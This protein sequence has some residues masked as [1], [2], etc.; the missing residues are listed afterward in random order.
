MP[1]TGMMYYAMAAAGGNAYIFGGVA[2]SATINKTY[3]YD[4]ATNAVT[5][6]ADMP[7]ALRSQVALAAGD[8]IYLI[9]GHT[10]PGTP[11]NGTT[12][13][14][15]Y[16]ISGDDWTTGPAMPFAMTWGA[17]AAY[18]DPAHGRVFYVFGGYNA[19]G[20]IVNQSWAY[21]VATGTWEATDNLQTA[22]RSH[23]G[24]IYRDTLLAVCGWGA[25][26]LNTVERG[27]IEPSV[28]ERSFLR[29][30][31]DYGPPDTTLGVRLQ[32]LGDTLTY[33]DVQSYTPTLTELMPYNA[34]GLHSNYAYND[35][36][37]LGN[38]LADY[39]D[40][41][42]GVVPCHFSYS[43]GWNLGGRLMTGDYAT[44]GVGT[45]TH[46]AT[47]LGW[48]NSGHPVMSGVSA[49]GEYFAATTSFTSPDSV[50]RW[51]DGRPYVA[52]SA[53]QK[54]V[55]V[56]SYPGIFPRPERTGDWA[57]VIRNA[58]HYVSG[59]V[60][61]EEFDPVRPA[62]SVRLETAPNPVR[63]QV[64]VNWALPHAGEV[65]VGI[66][67]AGGRLV[68]T[69]F[70]GRAEPGAGRASWNLADSRGERVASGV[71]FCC[72]DAGG[73]SVSSKLVVD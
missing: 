15:K 59:L 24:T 47:T 11:Y 50:A 26:F 9:G 72:L 58:L 63:R 30:Y 61:T 49:V 22:R 4:P 57:L 48:Y 1:Q 73:R 66:Y 65:S 2:A 38:V 51:T 68:R 7:M 46:Q 44:I 19:S 56:N 35:S 3:R 34:V 43:T 39:V 70:T 12:H 6:M 21:T 10:A 5:A 41:G 54:V 14:L 64:T 55:G 13:L 31:S 60:G 27:A 20:V 17:G 62:L 8:T 23:G 37:A 25:S 16:S 18:H 42:G 52:V 67:D 71:Y 29:L 32:A 53:N 69:L 28:A 33:L 40:A 36:V 45:N